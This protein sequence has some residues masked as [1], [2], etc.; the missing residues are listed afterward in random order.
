VYCLIN[1][2]GVLDFSTTIRNFGK[3]LKTIKEPFC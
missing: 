1:K 3:Y 2:G